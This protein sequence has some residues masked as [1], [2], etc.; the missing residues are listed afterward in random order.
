MGR[1]QVLEQYPLTVCDTGHNVN[2]LEYI[3]EQIM[4]N[5][6]K[7]LHMVIGM[8][9]DK[10]ISK[11]LSLLP[12][13]ATYYFCSAAIPRSLNADE[14][15]KQ[16]NDIGILGASYSSVRKAFDAA[17][18]NASVDDMIYIGGSTFVVAEIL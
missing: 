6:F 17:K 4:Q 13:N 16:G 1:W 14:L 10:D 8:V 11:M 9:N 12:K 15:Q 5:T 18:N 2:G 3:V 7:K